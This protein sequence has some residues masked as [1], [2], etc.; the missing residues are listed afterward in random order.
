MEK[1]NIFKG[2]LS[3]SKEWIEGNLII[4]KNGNSYIIPSEV[5]EPDGHHLIINSDSPFRVDKET[6]IQNK[7]P[8]K[9]YKI[10]FAEDYLLYEQFAE[11][12]DRFWKKV[13]KYNPEKL[14]MCRKWQGKEITILELEEFITEFNSI[15]FNGDTIKILN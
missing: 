6:V 8:M 3:H 1:E 10:E 7:I 5:F 14:E 13:I 9:K 4:D 2:K 11:K 12:G 15:I